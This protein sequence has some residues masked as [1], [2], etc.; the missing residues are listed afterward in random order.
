MVR[1]SN[2]IRSSCE[3]PL[4]PFFAVASLIY[5]L[6]PSK[7][8]NVK[9]RRRWQSTAVAVK[10][11]RSRL[12]TR[13]TARSKAAF[14]AAGDANEGSQTL[15]GR[16]PKK[17]SLDKDAWK[18]SCEED[19][20]Q[21]PASRDSPSDRGTGTCFATKMSRMGESRSIKRAENRLL[22]VVRRVSVVPT[23]ISRIPSRQLA[24]E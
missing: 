12:R 14:D 10:N 18:E 9:R 2:E 1:S 17:R 4:A 21:A 5:L 22:V 20:F 3:L 16:S 13:S 11:K 19:R 15:L 8:R 24:Y 23:A 6:E 7:T